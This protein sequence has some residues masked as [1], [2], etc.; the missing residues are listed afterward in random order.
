MD[1]FHG[2]Q[3]ERDAVL[4]AV[5]ASS[6]GWLDAESSKLDRWAEDRKLALE[7]ELKELDDAIRDTRRQSLG[8]ALLPEKLAMQQALRGLESERMK[9]RRELFESQDKVEVE[10]D[11][12]I[13]AM[14]QRLVQQTSVKPLFTIRWRVI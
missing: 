1:C 4:Q 9:K 10:R 12:L 14:Q 3:A 7:S 2:P 8:A 6:T 13:A 5:D 11:P